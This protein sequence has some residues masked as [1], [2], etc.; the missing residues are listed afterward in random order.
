MRGSRGVDRG[1]R[2]APPPPPPPPKNHQDIGFLSNT[3]QDHL[4]NHK[5]AKPAFN[6]WPSTA[7]QWVDPEGGSSG[8]CTPLENHKWIIMFP[9]KYWYGPPVPL[10]GRDDSLIVVLGFSLH[11][12][13]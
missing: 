12:M 13:N 8:P 1:S 10:A 3:G 11:L 5:A 9:Y 4:K 2:P 7:R 6:V